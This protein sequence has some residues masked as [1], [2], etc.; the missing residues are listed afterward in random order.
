MV[1]TGSTFLMK[2]ILRFIALAL[3]SLFLI[4]AGLILAIRLPAFQTWVVQRAA[5]YLSSELQTHVTLDRIHLE[6]F[7][8]L[9]IKGLY[10]EDEKGDTLLH[11]GEINSTIDLFSPTKG[12]IY[13]TDVTVKEAIFKLKKYPDKEGLN[14]DFIIRYFTPE[15][16][17]TTPASPFD[18]NPGEI[19]LEDVIFV[20]RD[21]RYHDKRDGM[22]FEDIRVEN[23]NASI[24]NVRFENDTI[25]A[26]INNITC[27]EKSGFKLEYFET[28]ASF[29]ATGMHF[30]NLLVKTRESQLLTNLTFNYDHIRHFGEFIEKVR[31]KSEFEESILSSNDLRYFAPELRG[32]DRSIRFSGKIRGTVNQLRGREMNIRYGNQSIFKGDVSIAGLPEFNESFFDLVVDELITDKSDIETIPLYPFIEGTTISLPDNFSKLGKA[33]FS[34]KFTGFFERLRCLRQSEY[35]PRFCLI[36][37]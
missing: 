35:G 32:F 14:L 1:S 22:D 24:D 2:R 6:F 3:L 9:S 11:A 16:K 5:N 13:L 7:R 4:A 37:H 12:K 20:Y 33:R 15:K 17:D 25:Y 26:T 31:M 36:R 28:D 27:R 34:G 8:T 18:F 23:I 29:S 30:E 21:E 19:N 10:I